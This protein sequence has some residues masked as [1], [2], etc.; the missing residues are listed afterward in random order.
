MR[1]CGAAQGGKEQGKLGLQRQVLEATDNT[2]AGA[3][4]YTS[5]GWQRQVQGDQARSNRCAGALLLGAVQGG[6]PPH[7]PQPQHG[8][9]G[10]GQEASHSE[11]MSDAM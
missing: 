10:G 1:L 2:G 9:P 6:R 4:R 8:R 5:A 3:L 11:V 7:T